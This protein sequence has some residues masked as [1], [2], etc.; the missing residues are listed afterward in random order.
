MMMVNL[1][2]FAQYPTTKVINGKE[3]VIMTVPQA[4][5]IDERYI[6]LKDSIKWLNSQ[7]NQIKLN[8]NSQIK[9]QDTIKQMIYQSQPQTEYDIYK[10]LE[11]EMY[12]K[13]EV[14]R[15]RMVDLEYRESSRK[16]TVWFT[17]AAIAL[18]VY[19]VTALNKL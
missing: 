17:T 6:K 4:K 5:N 14:E 7:L 10:K 18:V 9:T 8:N 13:M 12:R 19:F 16:I 1:S 3:V 11:L 15:Y 2:L